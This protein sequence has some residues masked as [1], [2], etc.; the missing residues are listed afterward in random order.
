MPMLRGSLNCYEK[1]LGAGKQGS[2]RVEKL[3]GAEQLAALDALL[4]AGERENRAERRGA[5]VFGFHLPCERHDLES[6]SAGMDGLAH[7]FIQHGGDDAAV[8]EPVRALEVLIQ[9][10]AGIDGA[11]LVYRETQAHAY[12]IVGAAAEAV[13]LVVEK[14]WLAR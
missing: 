3:C 5:Q 13:V 1:S 4:P 2:F 6:V 10:E 9:A 7:G 8:D 11:S 14:E 12:R